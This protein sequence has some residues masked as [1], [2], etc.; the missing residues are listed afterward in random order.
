MVVKRIPKEIWVLVMAAFAIALGYGLIAPILPQFARSFDVGFA[1][2]AAIVTVFALVRLAF[3]PGGGALV[4]RFGERR[5]YLVG[6]AIVALST[7]A[8]AFAQTYW[9]LL[10]FRGLGGIG[11]VMF[12]VSSMGLLARL[13]PPDIRGRT[14]SLYGSAFLLGNILGPSL[15]SAMH[16]LGYQ[17]PFLLYA[18]ALAIA[19]AIVAMFL[20]TERLAVPNPDSKPVQ[21]L[22][23][24]E[25]LSDSAYRALLASSF[26]NGWSNF[27]V[28]IA[29]LP[30]MAAAIPTLGAAWAGIAL[31]S[32]AIGNVV[33]QQLTG[34]LVDRRGRRPTILVGLFFTGAVTFVFGWNVSLPLFLALSVLAGMGTAFIA[35]AQQATLSDVLGRER[36]GGQAVAA[37]SMA[38]DF[39]SVAGSLASGFVADILG[40]GWAF[41]L[42]GGVLFAAT[43]PW[44]RA[45][46]P[47]ES[48]LA[49]Q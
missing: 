17:L 7:G 45:R 39:G 36:R 1:A 27:G 30:L 32:F 29:L 5:V 11:S 31:T 48:R 22:S 25:A 12:T 42:T 33:M 18:G 23:L 9:Q 13:S 19:T 6:L 3:A 2:A 43:I 46:E 15:G 20:S 47:L 28:R 41:A 24:R 16:G 8:V 10:L 34:R 26:A 38:G 35:P 37:V 21:T 44:L 14:S 4:Q 40:F 49:H